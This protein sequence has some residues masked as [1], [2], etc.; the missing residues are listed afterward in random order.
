[1]FGAVDQEHVETVGDKLFGRL[2]VEAR[3]SV[4]A[5]GCALV[6]VVRTSV[7]QPLSDDLGVGVQ[8]HG[9]VRSIQ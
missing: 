6:S 9:Q 2:L 5:A 4:A 7:T 8:D 1:L 3:F